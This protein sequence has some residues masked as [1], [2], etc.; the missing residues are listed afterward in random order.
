L[1]SS[2]S[3]TTT[4]AVGGLYTVTLKV[5]NSN[6]CIDSINKVIKVD[7]LNAKFKHSVPGVDGTVL[8]YA[9]DKTLAS[10]SWDF[11]DKSALGTDSSTSHQYLTKGRY[12]ATLTVTSANGCTYSSNSDTI[13]ILNTSIADAAG[14]GFNVEAY[15]NPFKEHTTI[16]YML[17]KQ[18]KVKL[19]VYDMMGRSISTL[20]DHTQTAGAYQV[21][22]TNVTNPEGIYILRMMVG[23]RVITKQI[24]MVK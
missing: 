6:G 17:E 18:S 5:S 15:P 3:A 23:D 2:K 11:N 4:Y 16:A 10:Y 19:E 14:S 24:T 13:I 22:F 7:S 12:V 9:N 1:A 8:F 20:V 21:Q